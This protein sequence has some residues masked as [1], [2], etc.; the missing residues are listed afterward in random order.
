MLEAYGNWKDEF[1]EY[2]PWWK[3]V[4]DECMLFIDRSL[5]HPDTDAIILFLLWL[6]AME[7]E[8]YEV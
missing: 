3:V 7:A 1:E 2:C 8:Q 5:Y 4:N 6:D